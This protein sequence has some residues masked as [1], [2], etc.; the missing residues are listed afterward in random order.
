MTHTYEIPE[1]PPSLSSGMGNV[2]FS[3][4]GTLEEADQFDF[5]MSYKVRPQFL[6]YVNTNP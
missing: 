6:D 3:V 5:G 1:A 4:Y 2:P